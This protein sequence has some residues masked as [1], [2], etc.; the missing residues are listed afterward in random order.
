M[1]GFVQQACRLLQR[2]PA[3][4]YQTVRRVQ[5][6]LE[7][8][9]FNANEWGFYLCRTDY[10]D[11]ALWERYLEYIAKNA[12]EI[13]SRQGANTAVRRKLRIVTMEGK[14]MVD[15][16]P[17]DCK[18]VFVN[19]REG[20]PQGVFKDEAGVV[21][22]DDGGEMLVDYP[23]L[24]DRECLESLLEHE[25]LDRGY[26]E[27]GSRKVFVKA[28]NAERGDPADKDG[29]YTIRLDAADRR[30]V[31]QSDYFFVQSSED[32]R[33]SERT[34][35][36]LSDPSFNIMKVSCE[37]LVHFWTTMSRKW[38][39]EWE[40]QWR[41]F[42]YPEM[43]PWE[44]TCLH[45][46]NHWIFYFLS[47]QV[48]AG[49]NP[50]TSITMSATHP[51][52]AWQPATMDREDFRSHL[53]TSLTDYHSFALD[54]PHGYRNVRVL[55]L[56]WEADM[57]GGLQLEPMISKITDVFGRHYNYPLRHVN[58]PIDNGND[59]DMDMDKDDDGDKSPTDVVTEALADALSILNNQCLLIVYYVG[60]AQC[61]AKTFR[62]HPSAP[63]T[64][65]GQASV[66]FSRATNRTTKAAGCDVLLLM[67]SC[68][69][70]QGA[71]LGCNEEVVA[72]TGHAG[73]A[74]W[75][76]PSS[77]TSN[78]AGELAHVARSRLI[79]TAT[80]LFALVAARAFSKDPNGNPLLQTM[81]LHRQRYSTDRMPIHLAPLHADNVPNEVWR[82][83][84][85]PLVEYDP[86]RVV[87]SAHLSEPIG[88]TF[89]RLDDWAT[90]QL[91]GSYRRIQF[92]DVHD[93]NPGVVVVLFKVPLATWAN[94]PDHPAVRFVCFDVNPTGISQYVLQRQQ[95]GLEVS[96]DALARNLY[97]G[98]LREPREHGDAGGHGR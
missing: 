62:L 37:E 92:E 98:R 66:D 61:D 25:K 59:V 64:R 77:F 24:A 46:I 8:G 74:R 87:L 82:A 10:S 52:D 50:A 93:A 72:A 49:S 44:D 57:T 81:P 68:Y 3:R 56:C 63:P 38:P 19:W 58:I 51:P 85:R 35:E 76:G 42:R 34:A 95:N 70:S 69:S 71:G 78:L 65:R 60:L 5:D 79:I 26:L 43:R 89:R 2:T 36:E 83:A 11:D 84:P 40:R 22:A 18:R 32:E 1:F 54:E 28:L 53:Q 73:Q 33:S 39:W 6:A 20:W 27:L 21:G 4:Q 23:L 15:A 41:A 97:P 13:V 31:P 12:R 88:L 45:N 91:P 16:S 47:F 94:M 75:N 48:K 9:D 96:L 90:S 86:V 7:E 14:D 30:V 55:T 80:E 67:D 29:M 17:D